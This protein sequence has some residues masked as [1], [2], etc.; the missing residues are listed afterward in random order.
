MRRQQHGDARPGG[1]RL[2]LLVLA[3][4]AGLSAMHGLSPMHAVPTAHAAPSPHATTYGHGGAE[5]M[6]CAHLDHGH[7]GG[8]LDHADTTCAATGTQSAPS[9]PALLP[10]G[11]PPFATGVVDESRH[12]AYGAAGGRAPPSL[13]ELQLLRI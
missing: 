10:A 2:V 12:A 1:P 11:L 6:A 3:V 5:E 9:L 8:H 7:G 4:I 13:S